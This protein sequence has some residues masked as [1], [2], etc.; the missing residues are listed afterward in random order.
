MS[1][2]PPRARSRPLRHYLFALSAITLL[3]L[4]ILAAADSFW[5]FEQGRDNAVQSTFQTTRGLAQAVQGELQAQLIGAQTLA[6]S[7]SLAA[8]DIARFTHQADAYIRL[9]PGARLAVVDPNETFVFASGRPDRV[10][11]SF[12]SDPSGIRRVLQG[13]QSIVSNVFT[14]RLNGQLM[15]TVTVPV[16]RDGR[17]VYALSVAPAMDRMMQILVRQGLPRDRLV[18]IFDRAGT[19]VARIPNSDAFLGK[20]AG[21]AL[22]A[23]LPT[24]D[25][26]VL[27]TRTLEGTPSLTMFSH[28]SDDGWSVA[29]GVPETDLVDPVWR[30][31]ARTMGALFITFL[32]SGVFAALIARRIV[33]PIGAL[34]QLATDPDADIGPDLAGLTE[35][36]LAIA[37]LKAAVAGR[38]AAEAARANREAALR[39]SEGRLQLA[40]EVAGQGT[41]D[42]DMVSGS[43]VWTDQQ[44]RLYGLEPGLVSGLEPPSTAIWLAAIHPDDR[45]AVI[46]RRA[47]TFGDRDATF[48]QEYRVIWPDGSV[49][50]LRAR[51]RTLFGPDDRPARGIVATIDVTASRE[52]AAAL[53][54]LTE[55]L[56]HRVQQEIA[57]RE[58]AQAQLAQAEKL[59]ALGQLSGGI[60]HDFNNIMQAVLG[61]A[62][63]IGKHADDVAKVRRLGTMVETTAARGI[64]I[65]RRLLSFARRGELRAEAIDSAVLLDGLHEVLT[66]TLGGSCAI[67]IDAEPHLPPVLADRGQL[68][69]VLVNLATNARDAMPLGGLITLSAHLDTLSEHRR[70]AGLVDGTYCRFIIEDSGTG[71]DQATLARS[72]EPFFTTKTQGHGTGLGL[73]MARGF[74]E[75]SGG[76]LTVVSEPGQGTTVTLWLPIADVPA[77]PPDAPAHRASARRSPQPTVLLVDDEAMVREVLAEQLGD[78]GYDVLQA[79]RGEAALALLDRGEPI[80]L[81]I[82]DLAMP[83]MNGIALLQAAHLRRP[84]TP[85]ILLTGNVGEAASLAI[86]GALSG[87]F[88]LLRKPVSGPQ[89]TDRI[90]ALLQARAAT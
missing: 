54:R 29:V 84:L 48:D 81:I 22:L 77:K 49:H 8:G 38:Q 51:A 40:Q 4:I 60:A 66:H 44:W 64:S 20:P 30:Q 68:E 28:L 11:T 78:A 65:T 74:A 55:Q 15:F 87:S 37:G 16:F 32:L 1:V 88:S 90:A 89:L 73:P 9:W 86:T 24:Q 58:A 42:F 39:A 47:A 17:V 69:T 46:A 50:W 12:R 83:G 59:T 63:L 6:L 19:S 79:D 82:S 56:E 34:A 26:G 57:A 71:M 14:D 43:Y 5:T 10:G 35:T 3:P 53:R 61:G 41:I 45:P 31:F 25:E 67:R 2:P 23:A 33:R 27:S 70:P 72:M 36:D 85:A 18:A 52:H 13:Q 62:S 76:A 80:D 21:P 75:Q 7:H